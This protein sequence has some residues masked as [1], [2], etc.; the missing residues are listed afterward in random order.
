MNDII[1][2]CLHK[3][4]EKTTEGEYYYDPCIELMIKLNAQLL[5]SSYHKNYKI[6]AIGILVSICTYLHGRVKL[7]YVGQNRR[8]FQVLL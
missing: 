2:T 8:I 4:I 1:G 7:N 6:G 3:T 5:S